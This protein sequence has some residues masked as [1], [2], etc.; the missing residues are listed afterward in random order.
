VKYAIV[1][2]V[3]PIISSSSAEVVE[4]MKK[5]AVITGTLVE[6]RWNDWMVVVNPDGDVTRWEVVDVR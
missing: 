1:L 4:A 5:L 6:S 2:K 3:D